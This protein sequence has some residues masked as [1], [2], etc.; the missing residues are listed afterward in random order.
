MVMI[1]LNPRVVE[2]GSNNVI[3]DFTRERSEQSDFR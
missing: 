2:N 3:R 1:R